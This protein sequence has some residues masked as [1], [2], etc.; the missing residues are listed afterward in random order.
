MIIKNQGKKYAAAFGIGSYALAF[1][2][3]PCFS[4]RQVLF[5]SS[6]PIL[7][8][9]L[10]HI[11]STDNNEFEPSYSPHFLYETLPLQKVVN[12]LAYSKDSDHFETGLSEEQAQRVLSEVGSNSLPSKKKT[13]LWELWL[14]QFDDGLVKILIGVAVLSAAFSAS[15]VWNVVLEKTDASTDALSAFLSSREIRSDIMQSFVE[16]GIIIAILLLNAVVGVWQDMSAR[17]SLESLE[18]MQPR[19]ATVLRD[20]NWFSDYEAK[21]LVPGDVIRFRVGDSIPADSR[22]IDL[23]SSTVYVDE[24]TLTGESESVSKNS[25]PN[26]YMPDGS[27]MNT[28]PIQDQSCML[29]SGTIVTRGSG[30]ALVVR[31][32]LNTQIGK[33]QSTLIEAK[34][35]TSERK[36]PLGEQLDQFGTQL[37]YI[38]GS[39]CVVVFMTSVPRFTDNVFDIWFEG[40]IYYAKVSVALGVAAIPEGLPAVITLCLSLGTRRMADR[41]VIVRK[42]PS[43]ETLGCTSVIC[44]GEAFE[45]F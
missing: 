3:T 2:G 11:S 45:N 19:L 33:I 37:S 24:S 13:S 28:I 36:T 21:L 30:K 35:A 25:I 20:S 29:F 17:S 34:S 5:S 40:A 43:V 18:K 31:T 32:G 39:I 7:S 12:I 9:T 38:I 14:Q 10:L 23:K 16:P 8:S 4:R 15:E 44:T 42:L 6:T 41:N 22:L 1:S 26:N 27:E